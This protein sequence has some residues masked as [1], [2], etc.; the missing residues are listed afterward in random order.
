VNKA[1]K[2]KNVKSISLSELLEDFVNL[3]VVEDPQR[4]TGLSDEDYINLMLK[5]DAKKIIEKYRKD[6]PVKVEKKQKVTIIASEKIS[7]VKRC[8]NCY[9]CVNERTIGGSCWCHCTNPGRSTEGSSGK[10]WMKSS[11]NLPCW[12]PPKD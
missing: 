11:L 12:R 4:V 9:Y 1:K 10:S 8:Q 3:D 5:K 6:E 7:P 2:T